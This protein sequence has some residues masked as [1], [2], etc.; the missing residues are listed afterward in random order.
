MQPT[1]K[2]LDQFYSS[3][4]KAA[5]GWAKFAD[6]AEQNFIRYGTKIIKGYYTLELIKS[7]EYKNTYGTQISKFPQD[8]NPDVVW[9]VELNMP[10]WKIISA[11][12]DIDT[13]KIYFSRKDI[14]TILDNL[15]KN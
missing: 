9:F 15:F 8:K 5:E 4:E 10:N 12:R 1:E 11:L 3:A 2:Q 6:K 7:K 14:D 13:D